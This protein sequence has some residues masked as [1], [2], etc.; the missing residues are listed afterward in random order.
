V[1]GVGTGIPRRSI[2]DDEVAAGPANGG[3]EAGSVQP[4]QEVVDLAGE[5]DGRVK[6]R[7]TAER[8]IG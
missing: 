1:L 3:L 7:R 8:A 2:D 5:V 6:R 4:E